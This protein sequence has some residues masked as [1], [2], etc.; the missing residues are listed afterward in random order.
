MQWTPH[1]ARLGSLLAV[2][3]STGLLV[4]YKLE[5]KDGVGEL[6]FLSSKS[7]T[8]PSTLVLSLAWHPC[9][10]HVIG[11]TLSNGK[12]S[13]C[14]STEG[15]LWTE[16]AV[17]YLT[18][19]QHHG[20]EAWCVA[21]SGPTSTN[22]LSGGDDVV[23]QCSHINDNHKRTVQWRDRKLHEAGI[24]AILPLTSDLAVTGSY[25]DHIRL[26]AFPTGSRR[27]VLAEHI[28][29]GGVWGLTLLAPPSLPIAEGTGSTTNTPDPKRFVRQNPSILLCPANASS[30]LY[31][32]VIS[33]SVQ[34]C[35]TRMTQSDITSA[36]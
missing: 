36:L 9:S 22:V 21:F 10:A 30:F 25:D 26:I 27:K 20:L 13:L 4:F 18:D 16:D 28:L 8:Q 32:P 34:P 11:L 17:V 24:T 31:V 29:G 5:V 1:G 3:T 14:E 15:E 2:A 33:N 35:T 23:L 19:I 6:A 12:V 7:V